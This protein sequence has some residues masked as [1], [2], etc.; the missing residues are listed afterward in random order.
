MA[1]RCSDRSA[2]RRRRDSTTERPPR[3]DIQSHYFIIR[4]FISEN[5]RAALLA[6]ILA[7][8]SSGVLRPN[9]CGPAR[10]F[11]KVDDE[12]DRFDC[13]LLRA[14]A[15]RAAHACR[16]EAVVT[17]RVLGRVL[18]LIETGGFIHAHTDAYHP[19]HGQP[20]GCHHLRCNIVAQLSH[21]S[22]RPVIEGEALDVADGDLWCFAA[23]KW[24]HETSPLLGD[25][26]PRVVCGFGWTVGGD[27]EVR[28]G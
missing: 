16:A 11:A 2:W 14:L 4:R 9:P 1:Q 6:Q 13:A 21:P 24:R 27:F 18:S 15:R 20:A 8:H 12:P 7:H 28:P 19:Q 17:D 23:S 10:Y 26:A 22:A 25:G 5:E 3:V